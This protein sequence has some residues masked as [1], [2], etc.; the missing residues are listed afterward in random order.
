MTKP[1]ATAKGFL[2][3][4][5][6]RLKGEV[7]GEVPAGDALCE[8]DCR[9]KQCVQGEWASCDR[10]L[11]HAAGELMPDNRVGHDCC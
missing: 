11:S 3:Q 1:K 10:R 4:I 7:V 2:V 6:G 9:K 8:Y 5:W